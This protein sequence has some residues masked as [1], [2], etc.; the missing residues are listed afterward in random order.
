MVV[1]RSLPHKSVCTSP[2][3][4]KN[5]SGD[6]EVSGTVRYC[7]WGYPFGT[8]RETLPDAAGN[9]LSQGIFSIC[10][11][12]IFNGWSET[13][14]EH[15]EVLIYSEEVYLQLCCLFPTGLKKAKT[16]GLK[17]MK[18]TADFGKPV[19][20]GDLLLHLLSELLFSFCTRTVTCGT[21][22]VFQFLYHTWP[23]FYKNF[24][25]LL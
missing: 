18:S 19:F 11:L 23:S 8:S 1:S 17:T 5:L 15:S 20:F 10:C 14:K 12:R 3:R 2:T 22:P 6:T 16:W 7:H 9:K 24:A 21:N 4:L 25:Y 13:S